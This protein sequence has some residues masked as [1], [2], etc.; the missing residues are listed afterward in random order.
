MTTGHLES[1]P[2]SSSTLGE[3]PIKGLQLCYEA[4]VVPTSTA[5]P[6]STIAPTSTAAPT[7]ILP[8]QVTTTIPTE[9]LPQV[10][11]APE[12][13]FTGSE[14]GP[15]VAVGGAMVLVGLAL[16]G[17]DRAGLARKGRHSR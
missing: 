1:P 7:S 10:E 12:I 9:V 5:A 2:N 11:T 16:V 17:V 14:T 3:A 6:T 13:A 4:A 8:E 15:L